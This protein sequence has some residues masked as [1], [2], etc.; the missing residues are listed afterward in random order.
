ML[1]VRFRDLFG[2]LSPLTSAAAKKWLNEA[3]GGYTLP[4]V[5]SR[6][7]SDFLATTNRVYGFLQYD[8]FVEDLE[9]FA[10]NRVSGCMFVVTDYLNQGNSLRE[11]IH[12]SAIVRQLIH[13]LEIG[14]PHAISDG[15][16]TIH[17]LFTLSMLFAKEVGLLT[18]GGNQQLYVIVGHQIGVSAPRGYRFLLHTHPT[19]KTTA[20]QVDTDI[21]RAKKDTV[22]I[23]ATQSCL[24]FYT[25]DQLVNL[26]SDDKKIIPRLDIKIQRDTPLT[27]MLLLEIERD[28][29]IEVEN[30]RKATLQGKT[31]FNPSAKRWSPNSSDDEDPFFGTH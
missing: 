15:A 10:F 19:A 9:T 18:D 29:L 17:E 16:V 12:L 25:C 20:S 27:R 21:T 3:Y 1:H 28:L 13:V 23:V 31:M 24:I 22:E 26:K 11:I 5:L 30:R 14:I 6:E 2:G 8:Q 4:E 7:L